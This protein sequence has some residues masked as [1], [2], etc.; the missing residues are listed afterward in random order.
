QNAQS[1]SSAGLYF[2]TCL[3]NW[4][5]AGDTFPADGDLIWYASFNEE[6]F[7]H[8]DTKTSIQPPGPILREKQR[9][10]KPAKTPSIPLGQPTAS[11][12]GDASFVCQESE[13]IPV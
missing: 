9:F 13:K 3:P 4:G 8:R 5:F 10:N 7:V 2:L 1:L 6:R 11:L 12:V